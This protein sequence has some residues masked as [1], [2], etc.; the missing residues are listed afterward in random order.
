MLALAAYN[1]LNYACWDNWWAPNKKGVLIWA[2][3]LMCVERGN[4]QYIDSLM[5]MTSKLSHW[6]SR[7]LAHLI[8]I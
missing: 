4:K 3:D 6:S 2:Q 1:A 7:F 5:F 8:I